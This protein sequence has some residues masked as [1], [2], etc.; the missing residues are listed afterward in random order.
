MFSGTFDTILGQKSKGFSKEC[1]ATTA[2]SDKSFNHKLSCIYNS[3]IAIKVEGN[4]LKDKVSFNCGNVIND[5]IVYDLDILSRDL[6]TTF[7]LEAFLFGAVNLT[8]NV[9]Q[10]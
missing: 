8:K 3:K 5:F 1:I 2:T 4:C 7:K 9:V 10:Y 6:N